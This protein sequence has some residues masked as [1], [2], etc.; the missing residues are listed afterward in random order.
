MLIKIAGGR[1]FDPTQG[2]AGE[3]RDLFIR[4]GRIVADPGPG[5]RVDT[6]YDASGCVVMAGAIDIHS[7]IAGG[8][9]NTARVLLP[10]QHRN[11]MARRLNHPHSTAKWSCTDTGY[12]YAR[13]GYTTVV[14][15][16]VLPVNALDAHLQMAD[17]PIIDTAGLAILGSDDF[18]LRLL[19]GGASQAQINDYV[20][21]TL[22]AT[23]CLGLK[24]INAGGA[25]A[26]RANVRQFDL[27]D[28]V[29]YYGTSSRHILQSLQRAVCDLRIDDLVRIEDDIIRI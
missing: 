4:D 23:R 14:E 26:F 17:I 3:V 16:A 25:A 11:F 5:A 6:V 2:L 28:V 12:R 20:A 1:V 29:P 10:E 27:D 22:Q 18:L 24:V 15:P 8:N 9:V 21:W 7:H 13:M 19:R